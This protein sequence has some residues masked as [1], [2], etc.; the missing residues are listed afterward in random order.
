M[1]GPEKGNGANIFPVFHVFVIFP[2]ICDILEMKDYCK[3]CFRDLIEV[4][5][6][7][8]KNLLDDSTSALD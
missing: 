3:P 4:D 6:L 1:A 5:V 2:D 8:V 7:Q